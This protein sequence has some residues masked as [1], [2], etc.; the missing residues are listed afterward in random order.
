MRTYSSGTPVTMDYQK[1]KLLTQSVAFLQVNLQVTAELLG[2]L[3]ESEVLSAEEV[4]TVQV[5]ELL[6]LSYIIISYCQLSVFFRHALAS[7][8]T[9]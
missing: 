2:A 7:G 4:S 6:I 1:R 5:R 8:P 3:K 9:S